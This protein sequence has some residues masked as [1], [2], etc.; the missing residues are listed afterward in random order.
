MNRAR[1]WLAQA[2]RD[3]EQ[4]QESRDSGRHEWACFAAQQS[5][6]TAVTALHFHHG[7]AALGHVVARLLAELPSGAEPMLIE[8][9]KVLHNFYVG[10]RY[11]NG[12][13][14]GAPFEHYGE[15]QSG[16]ALRYAGEIL[17]FVRSQVA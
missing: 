13:P 7:Q 11:P 5:A 1:D 14:E 4:A 12:H 3:L 2:E 17:A 8:K 10:T 15:I 6:E 9:A 16:E